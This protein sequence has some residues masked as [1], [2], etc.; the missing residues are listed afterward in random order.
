MPRASRCSAGPTVAPRMLATSASV[1]AANW[2]IVSMP[3]RCS[4]SSATGPMP[5][6]RRTGNPPSSDRSSAR[7]T[8][9]MPSG[10]ASPDAI[11]AICLPEPAPD[12]GD[13]AGLV[14]H[15]SPQVLAERLDVVA[16]TPR[17]AGAVRRS[18]RRR[19][20]ARPPAPRRGPC[21]RR[22]GWPPRRP[23]RAAATPPRSR[24]SGGG[25]GASASPSARRTRAP[26]SWRRPPRRG[27]PAADQHRPAPQGRPGELFDGGE[28]RVHVEVQH[29]TGLHSR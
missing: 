8:T 20:A 22:G 11:L 4:F 3:S 2:P 15:P 7:R 24:R 21:R 27:R 18:P 5:H 10:L 19:T 14:A 25:P 9:R 1:R 6:S 29:P 12:R 13:Q 26:R 23:R 17:P 16:P 28:E